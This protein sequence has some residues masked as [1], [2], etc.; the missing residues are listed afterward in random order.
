MFL[1]CFAH[2]N[3]AQAF[4][5]ISHYTR[6]HHFK[7]DLFVDTQNHFDPILIT[8]EG[9]SSTLFSV[10]QALSL[11]S[12][13]IQAVINLGVAGAVEPKMELNHIYP[14]RSVYAEN[15]FKSFTTS[16]EKSKWDIISVNKRVYAESDCLRFLPFAPLIDRELWAI[17]FA[18][19]EMQVPF[20]AYKLVS[21]YA[22]SAQICGQVQAQAKIFSQN[23][24]L[25]WQETKE[26]L[27]LKKNEIKNSK[28]FPY[29]KEIYLTEAMK[30]QYQNLMNRLSILHEK[31]SSDI[32]GQA[33]IQDILKKKWT[34]KKKGQ[35]LI[36][37]LKNIHLQSSSGLKS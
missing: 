26:K 27:L 17:G 36:N 37:N 2:K 32:L 15:E 30:N 13:E 25:Y 11:M 19:K 28:I 20:Y 31:K 33:L 22:Q 8:G 23:L 34:A 5:K 4:L 9:M 18:A 7:G 1:L 24:A 35:S 12:S 29:P 21:D 3:E 6:H 14:I 10:T 16:C